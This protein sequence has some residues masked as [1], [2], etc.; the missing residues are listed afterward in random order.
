MRE[1]EAPEQNKGERWAVIRYSPK[2]R[3]AGLI[4]EMFRC[5]EDPKGV[6]PPCTHEHVFFTDQAAR[7][8]EVSQR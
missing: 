7:P 3:R 6:E 2:A 1:M 8:T 4:R 5:V